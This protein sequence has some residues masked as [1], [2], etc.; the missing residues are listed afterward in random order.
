MLQLNE[1]EKIIADRRKA[2]LASLINKRNWQSEAR[3]GLAKLTEWELEA[4]CF[5]E[6]TGDSKEEDNFAEEDKKKW[7]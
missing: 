1:F 4:N 7:K 3:S 6:E 5:K 2:G